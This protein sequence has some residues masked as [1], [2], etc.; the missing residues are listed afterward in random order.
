MRETANSS[1]PPYLTASEAYMSGK[2]EGMVIH[3]N[4][5]CCNKRL[6]DL[7]MESEAGNETIRIKCS[8][9][10]GVATIKPK[11]YN[12]ERILPVA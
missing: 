6:F 7:E 9:C 8:R 2:G 3:V 5:P 4:C 11:N 10:R 1:L 12:R